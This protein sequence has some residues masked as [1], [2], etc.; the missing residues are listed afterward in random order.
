MP[1]KVN[2]LTN[3]SISTS[4]KKK[5]SIATKLKIIDRNIKGGSI[6]TISRTL[7]MARTILSYIIKN[8]QQIQTSSES[9]SSFAEET[10]MQVRDSIIQITES[11]FYAWIKDQREKGARL[12]SSIIRSKALSIY[13][14]L[15]VE[16]S[17]TDSFKASNGWFPLFKKRYCL[18]Q[19]KFSGEAGH[20]D[21]VSASD[22]VFTLRSII[23][24]G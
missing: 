21:T 6:G 14:S 10:A 24:E 3:K 16:R 19:L 4:V 5:I 11:L 2:K 18:K 9:L 7:G 15:K 8:R 23:S 17:C 1:P 13:E 22:Y 12:N 20:A